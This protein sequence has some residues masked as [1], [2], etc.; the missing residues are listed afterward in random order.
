MKRIK[1]VFG[2]SSEVFHLWANQTQT[3]ARQSGKQTR[4]GG[5]IYSRAYFNGKSCFSYGSH[6]ELGRL[7]T[8]DGN[9]PVAL[10]RRDSAG[11]TTS[12]HIREAMAACEHVPVIEVDSSFNW[13]SGLLTMQSNL[14][15]SLMSNLSRRSAWS[16]YAAFGDDEKNR[17]A[18]FNGVCRAVG[19]PELQLLPDTELLSVIN[20]NV[21]LAVQKTVLRDQG[22]AAKRELARLDAVIKGKAEIEAWKH[23]GQFTYAVS[24]LRPQILRVHNGELQTSGHVTMPV[25]EARR[26]LSQITDGSLPHG[27]KIGEGFEYTGIEDG[28]IKV[29]CHR[30]ELEHAKQILSSSFAVIQGGKQWASTLKGK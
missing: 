10:I 12:K 15:D 18:K 20:E 8:I 1:K 28:V 27:S 9:N 21:L 4:D 23:G 29:G 17:F 24:Q 11:V 26:V 2:S 6:Y 3:E 5:R 13:R 14:I 30:I 19:K 16:E 7:V 22:H 25:M